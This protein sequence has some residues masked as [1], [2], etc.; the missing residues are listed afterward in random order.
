MDSSSAN[1]VLAT[2]RDLT[3]SGRTIICT[4][5]QASASQLTIFDVLYILTPSGQCIYHGMT[6]SLLDYLAI[7]G[8]R[9]PLY[10]NTADYS[11]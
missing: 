10:H 4:I 11:Q 3:N 7:Q 8:L 9:C 2:L 1:Q 6:A 5:H